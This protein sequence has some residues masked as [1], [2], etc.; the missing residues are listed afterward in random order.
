MRLRRTLCSQ[1][2]LGESSL[3]LA[4]AE[5]VVEGRL[6]LVRSRCVKEGTA[7]EVELHWLVD[8]G[9][10]NLLFEAASAGHFNN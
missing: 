10:D 8:D 3:E 2:T 9:V 6:G 1:L 7:H 4:L 5:P